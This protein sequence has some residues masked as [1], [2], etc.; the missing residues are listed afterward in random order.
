MMR[1]DRLEAMRT[2]VAVADLRSFTRA[3]TRLA[4]SPSAVTRLVAALEGHLS[5]RLLQRTTRRVTL[6]AEG[7]RYLDRARRILAD[8]E[9]AERASRS[10]SA[11]PSGR[12]VVAAPN[13][14]GRREVAPL[15]CD[16]LSRHPAV[17]GELTLADRP[18]DLVEEG[19]DVAIR[20]GVL[21]DSS[22]RVRAVG[23]TRRVAVASPDYL[24]TH[25][26]IRVP[27]DLEK[28]ATIQFTS[29]A[30]AP[31]WRFSVRGGE[32]RVEIRPRLVTNSADAAIGHAERGGGVTMVLSY[33]VAGQLESG[34][35][36]VVLARFEPPPLPIQI[37]H[38]GG[39]TPSTNV[40]AFIDLTLETRRWSFLG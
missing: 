36:E 5:I 35:L 1:M 22:L 34:A 40:R 13:V 28:H 17:R 37:V 25:P 16:Y 33:Q 11:T 27:R 29:L 10:E 32:Q 23:T 12:F 38:P 26:R 7:A 8:L 15:L 2:F 24:A 9:D 14:F 19:V 18:I 39:R 31:E 20:I 3:A 4:R 30:S 21:E 6:T